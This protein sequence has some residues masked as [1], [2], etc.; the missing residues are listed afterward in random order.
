ML[1]FSWLCYY[2]DTFEKSELVGMKKFPLLHEMTES[3]GLVSKSMLLSV[4]GT[5]T[6]PRKGR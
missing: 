2:W 1:S 4:D 6:P 5:L 3:V